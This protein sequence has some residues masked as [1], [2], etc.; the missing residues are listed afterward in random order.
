[1]AT[2]PLNSRIRRQL[3]VTLEEG[4]GLTI[5]SSPSAYFPAHIAAPGTDNSS[6]DGSPRTG[7]ASWK[8][9]WQS[10]PVTL[11]ACDRVQAGA[12]LHRDVLELLADPRPLKSGARTVGYTAPVLPITDLYPRLAT[13]RFLGSPDPLAV[14]ACAVYQGR[15]TTGGRGKYTDTFCEL[16]PSA[17]QHIQNDPKK[18]R[19]LVF[20]DGS[21]WKLV[22]ATLGA[23]VPFVTATLRK[24]S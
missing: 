13:M 15:E 21:V 6:F 8:L 11:K 22:E 9:D 5:D 7:L 3:G 1:M 24:A 2:V 10:A 16:E 20:G 17:W 12:G 18:N 23:E 4:L 19:E 14:V